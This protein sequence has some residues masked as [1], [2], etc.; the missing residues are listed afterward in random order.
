MSEGEAAAVGY[1]TTAASYFYPKL[2]MLSAKNNRP[3]ALQHR[4]QQGKE[5][6]EQVLGEVGCSKCVLC[7]CEPVCTA[8]LVLEPVWAGTNCFVHLTLAAARK[9]WCSF[10]SNALWGFGC[11]VLGF[12][13]LLPGERCACCGF[14]AIVSY[15]Y[16]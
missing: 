4:R 1:L 13:G 9:E 11:G 15:K 16:F 3:A 5:E 14:L 7:P 8:C 2:K 12:F 10:S 6:E